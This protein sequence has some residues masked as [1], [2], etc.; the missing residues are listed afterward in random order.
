LRG[1]HLKPEQNFV[2]TCPPKLAPDEIE[3]EIFN[4]LY[5]WLRD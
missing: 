5:I 3:L 1:P 4:L 2:W